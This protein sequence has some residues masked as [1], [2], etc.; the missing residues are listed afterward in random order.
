MVPG[1]LTAG[2]LIGA[3]V[4]GR[5]DPVRPGSHWDL[6]PLAVVAV[7]I[8]LA[9]LAGAFVAGLRGELAAVRFSALALQQIAL[10]VGLE[11]VEHLASG[12]GPADA[13]AERSLLVGALTQVVVAGGL[14]LL[15]G[16][17]QRVGRAVAGDLASSLAYQARRPWSVTSGP[18]PR[19]LSVVLCTP[20]RGP[21]A[22]LRLA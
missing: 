16:A 21:P 13:L 20:H 7:P 22:R 6:S 4:A 14:A 9:V 5:F 3:G 2:H 12:I 18:D 10:Y 17:L 1:G 8:T 11:L 19:K 15:I